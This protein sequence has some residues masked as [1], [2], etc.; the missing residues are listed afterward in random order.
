MKFLKIILGLFI[1][2]IS[3]IIFFGTQEVM[4]LSLA[5]GTIP[6]NTI[7]TEG[8]HNAAGE[9]GTEIVEEDVATKITEV[10]PDD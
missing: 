5:L 8:L 6:I 4:G 2:A 1:T 9:I 10:R 3:V 7:D